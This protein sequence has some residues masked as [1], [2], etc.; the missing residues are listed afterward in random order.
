MLLDD[1]G[2]LLSTGGIG[3]VGSTADYGIYLGV[4]PNS[5]DKVVSIN[6]TGGVAPYRKM[7]ATAGEVVAE[8]PRVQVIV[9]TTLYTSG[10]QKANDAWKLLESLPERTINSTRYLYAES[11][12]S[13][14]LIGRDENDRVMIGFNVDIVK[15]LSTA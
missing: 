8:R 9:R 7:T 6:E 14:F 15:A 2:D 13:P 1:I 12:Q 4:M 10:R 3:T 5:P 11:V